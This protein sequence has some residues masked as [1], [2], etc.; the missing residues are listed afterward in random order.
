MTVFLIIVYYS[1][2]SGKVPYVVKHCQER[3]PE[4]D[5]AHACQISHERWPVV[6]D[7]FLPQG[8]HG[9]WDVEVEVHV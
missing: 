1:V 8:D 6:Y 2:S 9:F 5:A 3:H 4:Q 7:K